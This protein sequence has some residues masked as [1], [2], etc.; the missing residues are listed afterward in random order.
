MKQIHKP[1]EHETNSQTKWAWNKFTWQMTL[2]KNHK[3]NEHET[4][5]YNAHIQDP[6]VKLKC[7]FISISKF[8]NFK[9][10]ALLWLLKKNTKVTS[11]TTKP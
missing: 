8:Y 2:K 7:P 1:N 3:T 11:T 4:N 9:T 10:I 6:F 5:N